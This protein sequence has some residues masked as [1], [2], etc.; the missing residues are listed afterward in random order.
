MKRSIPPVTVVTTAVAVAI[1]FALALYG[2]FLSAA[3]ANAR[4][5]YPEFKHITQDEA[6]QIM[7]SQPDDIVILDVRT[8]EEYEEGHIPG[9]VCIPN[10]TIDE[11]VVEQL[12]NKDQ[13]ILVYC[14]S[15]RRSQEAAYTLAQLGYTGIAEM[16]GLNTWTG[17]LVAGAEPNGPQDAAAT[18]LSMTI[19]DAEVSVEWEDNA[20]VQALEQMAAPGPLTVQ[21]SMYGGFEQVGSL[22]APLPADDVQ[23]TTAAG[24]VV[25]YAGDQ[26][27]VFYGSNAWAYT[28]LGHITDKTADEMADLLGN[29]D[30]TVTLSVV[31][32]EARAPEEQGESQKSEMPEGPERQANPGGSEAPESAA[33][34]ESPAGPTSPAGPAAPAAPAA[35]AGPTSSTSPGEQPTLQEALSE[36]SFA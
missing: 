1:A 25:L 27:V 7:E 14:R 23:T 3:T 19:G 16:G 15:G 20:A 6:A 8:R 10:E 22:G 11:R 9:A 36:A 17:E 32:G 4:D 34:A 26:I 18:R 21:M 35:P 5:A 24:D 33:V 13:V 28:R 12:P 31:A 29:G 2:C 30:V